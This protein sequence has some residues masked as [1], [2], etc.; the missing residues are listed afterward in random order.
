ML[1]AEFLDP[2]SRDFNQTVVGWLLERLPEATRVHIAS[3]YYEGSVLDWLAQPLEDLIKRCGAVHCLIGSNGGQT[4]RVDLERLLSVLERS[5]QSTLY[6][7]YAEGGLF[8]PKVYAVETK[9][10]VSALIGSAN[11]TAQGSLTNVEAGIALSTDE[12]GPP[13]ETPLDQILES[14]QPEKYPGAIAINGSGDLDRLEQLGVIGRVLRREPTGLSADRA[15][16]QRRR[17]LNVGLATR[18]LVSGVPART[19]SRVTT[20][21]AAS[22]SVPISAGGTSNY[23]VLR[24]SANDLKDTGTREISASRGIREWAEHILGRALAPGEGTLFEAV[25]EARLAASPGAIFVSPEPN[26]LWVAGGS[27]GTHQDL[28]LVLGIPLKAALD[29]EA[30]L[31]TGIPVMEESIGVFELPGDPSNAPIRL[32]VFL[33]TD[34]DWVALDARLGTTGREQKPHFVATSVPE[35]P[36]WP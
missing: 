27:G 32:T 30:T 20:A 7:E 5:Q 18:G 8:H 1:T 11:F 9:S 4:Q 13:P 16:A 2:T 24:F 10:S 26:R 28:R 21:T 31:V 3:G 35:L 22:L 17:R 19:R 33:P 14:L 25:I 6:V 15:A 29:D 36:P 12:R 23:A 34:P